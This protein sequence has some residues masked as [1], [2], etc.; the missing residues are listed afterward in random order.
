VKRIAAALL[1]VGLIHSAARAAEAEDSYAAGLNARHEGRTAEAVALLGRAVELRENDADAWLQYGLALTDAQRWDEAGRALDRAQALAPAYRD[2]RLARA[3]LAWFRGDAAAARAI[4]QPL[5]QSGD[6]EARD[7]ISRTDAARAPSWRLDVGGGYSR[8]SNGLEPWRTASASLGRRLSATTSVTGS[9]E[10]TERFGRSDAYFEVRGDHA[11]GA[12]DG[13]LAVGGAPDADYRPQAALR[14]GGLGPESTV[15]GLKLRPTLDAGWARYGVGDV[16]TVQPGLAVEAGRWRLAG[17]WIA[18]W[19][20][21]DAFRSGY[22]LSGGVEVSDRLQVVAG[23][24]DA[25]ESSEGVTVKVRAASFGAIAKVTDRTA[26]RL[27]VTREDRGAYDRT[28]LMAAV[29][30]RF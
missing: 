22:A 26:V 25:P 12:F 21:T 28:E 4:A 8:L 18:T 6:A 30:K 13:Y 19:D 7:L 2:V 5:A 9:A 10:W 17:R 27:D 14:A 3:R 24:A 20:E 29:T 23:W 15:G 16:R 1:A 11:F